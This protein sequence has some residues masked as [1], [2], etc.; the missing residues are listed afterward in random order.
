MDSIDSPFK[1]KFNKAIQRHLEADRART[2]AST[3]GVITRL[4]NERALEI[5]VEAARKEILEILNE[6]NKLLKYSDSLPDWLLLRFMPGSFYQEGERV[7]GWWDVERQVQAE[8]LPIHHCNQ[9]YWVNFSTHPDEFHL[10]YERGFDS[11]K[12]L[13]V[14]FG[15]EPSRLLVSFPVKRL[16]K[17]IEYGY[18]LPCPL[19]WH[20]SEGEG[21]Y[22]NR[23][24]IEHGF[25]KAWRWH[26]GSRLWYL[27][28]LPELFVDMPM[29]GDYQFNNQERTR[30]EPENDPYAAVL[31]G[32]DAG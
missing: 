16:P 2:M 14:I 24:I 7:M 8:H 21:L 1:K 9:R 15:Y 30:Y 4:A 23:S 11:P 6:L 17:L 25:W 19:Q 26:E 31:G 18:A 20:W 27:E 10:W 3:K 22:V 29:W 5:G 28:H 32:I 13:P 12:E